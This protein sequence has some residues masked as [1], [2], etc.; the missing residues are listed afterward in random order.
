MK[1]FYQIIIFIFIFYYHI[2]NLLIPYIIRKKLYN[3][4]LYSLKHTI[5]PYKPTPKISNSQ[6][7]VLYVI[8][9]LMN[10]ILILCKTTATWVGY[11][12]Y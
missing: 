12:T 9:L 5:D 4:L 10:R 11:M 3:N 2:L 8:N 7:N 1:F 6:S